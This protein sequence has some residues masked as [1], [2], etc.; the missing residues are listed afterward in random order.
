MCNF[1][2]ATTNQEATR[3]I[4]RT[5]A[6]NFGN[7]EPP[8]DACPDQMA[9]IMPNTTAGRGLASVRW[10]AELAP[11]PFRAAFKHAEKLRARGEELV[12]GEL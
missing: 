5:M 11:S 9:P 3:A 7:L 12:F 2:N 6:D 1:C 8:F 4:T 10:A